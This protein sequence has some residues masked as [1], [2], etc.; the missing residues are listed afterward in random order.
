MSLKYTK[1]TKSTKKVPFTQL[2]PTI[3]CYRA[4]K[5]QEIDS[6]KIHRLIQISQVLH[7][8]ISV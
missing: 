1:S 7:V 5:N 4:I 2:P 3:T 8:L 6:G